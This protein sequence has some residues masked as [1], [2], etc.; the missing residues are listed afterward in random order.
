MPGKR[1]FFE[2]GPLRFLIFLF[3]G[4]LAALA[5]GGVVMLVWNAVLPDVLGVKE[6]SYWQ[7][8]G[9]L[10][11]CRLLFGS[12]R[13]KGGR[14]RHMGPSPQLRAKLMNM[15]EEERKAFKEEMRKRCSPRNS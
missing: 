14:P 6:I 11:L 10:I 7:S 3:L 8:V 12:F 13:P 1:F 9:L 5:V 4:G 2:I 15:S